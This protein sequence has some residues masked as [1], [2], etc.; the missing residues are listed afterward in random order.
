[1]SLLG[2]R[3]YPA[4]S[5]L[6]GYIARLAVVLPRQ[7]FA[8]RVEP[9]SPVRLPMH[10]WP[11]DVDLYLHMNNGRY[12]TLMDV[13]RY[14]WSLR[15]G[16]AQL[17]LRRQWWPVLSGASIVYRRELRPMQRFELVTQVAGWEGKHFWF[18]HRIE[19]GSSVYA[20]ALVQGVIR[21]RGRSLP[22][23]QVMESLGVV[24]PSP[25]VPDPALPWRT[26]PTAGES[27]PRP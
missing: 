16:F 5:M 3:A 15:T 21:A 11:G 26:R 22:F 18:E 24:Q 7:L 2:G 10:V 23:A 8:E 19:V 20:S 14:Q 9:M 27:R 12:L 25:P 17:M 1:M 13:G 4:A 6:L